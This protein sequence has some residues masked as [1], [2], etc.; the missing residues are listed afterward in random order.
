MALEDDDTFITYCEMHSR[1]ERALFSKAHLVRL[2]RLAD[3]KPALEFLAC[4]QSQ[5]LQ[6][7]WSEGG[8]Q[9]MCERARAK[10]KQRDPNAPKPTAKIIP[11]VRKANAHRQ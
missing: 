2:A 11:F 10:L 9:I 7:K 3:D 1:T 6:A 4:D 5:F 8:I